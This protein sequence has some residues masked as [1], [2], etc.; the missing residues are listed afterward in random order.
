MEVALPSI[1]TVTTPPQSTSKVENLCADN[2]SLQK[3]ISALH[4]NNRA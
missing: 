2:A 3:Q 1:A 4:G